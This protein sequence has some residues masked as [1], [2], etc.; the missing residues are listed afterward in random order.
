MAILILSFYW[1]LAPKREVTRCEKIGR[2]LLCI[3]VFVMWNILLVLFMNKLD[4][5]RDLRALE[6]SCPSATSDHR[7]SR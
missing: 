7:S 3:G 5:H 2:V 4:A 6:T 1:P